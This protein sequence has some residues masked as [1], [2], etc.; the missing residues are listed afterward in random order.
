MILL[1]F[2]ALL[3]QAGEIGVR[4]EGPSPNGAIWW[5][6]DWNWENL[7]LSGCAEGALFPLEFRRASL[8][9]IWT[10]EYLSLS[11]ELTLFGSFR[12]DAFFTGSA[13]ASASF[14]GA[15]LTFQAGLKAGLIAVNIAPS[16]IFFAWGFVHVE[17]GA[18]SA[19][20]NIDGPSPWR[21]S[22]KVSFG[23]LSVNL[24]STVSL[25]LSEVSEAFAV[26]AGLQILPRPSQFHSLRW[27]LE[28]TEIRVFLSSS[29]QGWLRVQ[30]SQEPWT[31]L[32]FFSFGRGITASLE[33]RLS[34]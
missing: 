20:L 22:S 24:G 31:S 23:P 6:E 34:F 9:L 15:D 18:F 16:E 13:K 29:G 2:L 10:T 7:G 1:L 3:G 12:T 33:V 4:F 14:W 27:T 8:K 5:Q 21:A 25:M 30:V 17:K 19:E 32:A 11:P 28:N 26:S